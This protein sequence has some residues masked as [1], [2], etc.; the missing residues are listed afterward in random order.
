MNV[1]HIVDVPGIT[2]GHHSRVGRGWQTGTTV[3]IPVLAAVAGVDVRGSAPGTRETDLL[4]P[5]NLIQRIHGLCLSGG[6]AYGLAAAHGVM[7]ELE[8]RGRG[9]SVGTDARWVVPIVPSA[10][11]FDLGRGGAFT[12]RPD[13]GFGARAVRSASA[14]RRM[15]G[16]VGAGV[17]ARAGGLQG[18]VGSA[19]RRLE[20][21]TTVGALVVVNS[22][23]SVVDADSG[24]PW[25]TTG[26]G[27]V[28]PDRHDR[29]RLR[30]HLSE[31]AVTN[32]SSSESLNTVIGAVATDVPLDKAECGKVASVAHD[33]LARSV[34]PAHSMNDGDTIFAMSSAPA[35]EEPRTLEGSFVDRTGRV[36]RLNRVLTVAAEVFAQAVTSAVVDAVRAGAVPSYRD[37]CPS[38][39]RRLGNG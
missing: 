37:L 4:R 1:G 14:N 8:S 12:N 22:V 3:V 5:E 25:E 32:G 2:V 24:L 38:A 11:I 7:E 18:G 34:R 19:S 20:D 28:T 16:T 27:L 13:A 31:R 15:T 10:V 36:A 17:G 29:R 21:G 26:T 6:S 23:G 33:G 39:Y 9:F 30:D 35:A